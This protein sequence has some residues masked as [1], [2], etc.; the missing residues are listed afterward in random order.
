[1]KAAAI[2]GEF[3][4]QR[5]THVEKFLQLWVGVVDDYLE[6]QYRETI[7]QEP[8]PQKL[9][10]FCYDCKWLLKTALMLDG[11]VKDPDFPARQFRAEVAGKLLQLQQS[12]ERLTD[13]ISGAEA[14]QILRT[15]FPDDPGPRVAS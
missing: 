10:E 3:P 12:Y 4:A 7:Q 14:E 2:A 15:A 6:R 8:S 1:M 11:T 13:P 9:A 5:S